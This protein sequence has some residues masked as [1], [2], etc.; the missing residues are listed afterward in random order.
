MDYDTHN[1]TH[2]PHLEGEFEPHVGSLPIYL[3]VYVA[4]LVLL[5][6]TVGAAYIDLGPWGVVLAFLIAAVKAAL[7][8]LFFMHLKDSGKMVW[9]YALVGLIWLATMIVGTLNDY[10]TR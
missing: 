4:L 10:F 3:A 6:A 8:A 7:V 5:G 9:V 1:T 2:G